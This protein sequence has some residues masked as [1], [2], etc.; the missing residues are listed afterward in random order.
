MGLLLAV[1][2]PIVPLLLIGATS[3]ATTA[4]LGLFHTGVEREWWEGP[5]SCTG[6]GLDISNLSGADLLPS[7]TNALPNVVM[8]D[9]VVWE[10]LTLSMA[11]WNALWSTVLAG[12]WLFA[13]LRELQHRRAQGLISAQ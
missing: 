4:A 2:L 1:G 13:C 9:E 8:C 12:L 11:S 7:A 6:S 3:A 5:A 10:F